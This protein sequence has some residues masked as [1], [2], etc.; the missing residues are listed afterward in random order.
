MW[1]HHSR[2]D[3]EDYLSHPAG[4]TLFNVPQN[5][6]GL[7][8]HRDTLLA[9]GQ[10]VV[11]RIVVNSAFSFTVLQF[12]LVQELIAKNIWLTNCRGSDNTI[13][14]H[15]PLVLKII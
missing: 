3:G 6:T 10:P 8:G 15:C 4:H 13:M 7:L 2:V 5:P 1:P 9:H 11:L 14:G 12:S